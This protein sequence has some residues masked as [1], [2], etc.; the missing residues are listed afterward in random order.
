MKDE[1]QKERV[2]A[3]TRGGGIL[4]GVSGFLG[5]AR[6]VKGPNMVPF[7]G[8]LICS[9]TGAVLFSYVAKKFSSTTVTNNDAKSHLL[10]RPAP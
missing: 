1:E 5:G 7:F 9:Y 10:A 4:G 3:Y 2:V 6:L 8:A